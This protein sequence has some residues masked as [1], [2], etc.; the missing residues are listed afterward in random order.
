MKASM[1]EIAKG[2]NITKPTIYQY[3]SNKDDLFFSLMTPL[4]D[5]LRKSLE[6]VQKRL[7]EGGFSDGCEFIDALFNALY[8]SYEYNNDT[9]QIIQL[10]QQSGFVQ[11]LK[12]DVMDALKNG[13]RRNF[14][15]GRTIFNTAMKHGLIR[16][17][18][19]DTLVDLLWGMI[20]GVIQLEDIKGDRLQGH[21]FKK[22]VIQMAKE[23]FV[24][25]LVT[26]GKA[27]NKNDMR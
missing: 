3:F 8:S 2:A 26:N 19:I 18:E 13:G 7:D 9:F 22:R 20:V 25:F 15:L 6:S 21:K 14:K 12:P 11:E 17:I 5:D 23:L 16:E 27:P 1:E 4:I 10:F 24:T